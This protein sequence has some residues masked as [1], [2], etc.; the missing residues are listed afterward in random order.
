MK[1]IQEALETKVDEFTSL[2][3]QELSKRNSLI[4]EYI[5]LIV[6]NMEAY[7]AEF[8]YNKI[9]RSEVCAMRTLSDIFQHRINE[10]MNN[11][12]FQNVA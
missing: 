2:S 4:R 10:M 3:T 11:E 7:P 12:G 6:S 8:E 9:R 5:S 1:A